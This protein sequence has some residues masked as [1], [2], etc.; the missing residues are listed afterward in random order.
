MRTLIIRLLISMMLLPFFSA[1]SAVAQTAAESIAVSDA[2]IREVPPVS[3]TSA[4]FMTLT[5]SSNSDLSL[6]HAESDAAN[7]VEL[8][9][10]ETDE[11]GIHRMFRVKMIHIPANGQAMLK[12]MSYH[13][14]LIGLKKPLKEGDEVAIKLH[15]YDG[16]SMDVNVPVK[17]MKMSIMKH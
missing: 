11:N 12:P 1:C 5:N 16:S 10:H 2:W 13:I 17:K 3:E 9:T 14:M 7:F 15:F 6:M 4:I 8:H